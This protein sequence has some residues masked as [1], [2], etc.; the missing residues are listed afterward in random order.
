MCSIVS[1][2]IHVSLASDQPEILWR[3]ENF[4]IYRE[5]S[6]PVSSKGHIIVVFNLHVPSLYTLCPRD[7]P[8]LVSI[9]DLSRR[10][11]SILHDPSFNLPTHSSQFTDQPMSATGSTTH[12][13]NTSGHDAFRIGFITPPFRDCK[14]PITDHLHAHAY[15]LPADQMGWF[16]GISFSPIAWYD[17]DDLIA[18]IREESTNNRIRSGTASRPIDSVPQAGARMGTADGIERTEHP[19]TA[20]HLDESRV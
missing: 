1:S 17:I 12:M 16:R 18:E 20:I 6:N 15:V 14:I 8:L 11:L 9:R 3:D 4:T 19:L 2:T 10:L 5:R 13:T 7:L